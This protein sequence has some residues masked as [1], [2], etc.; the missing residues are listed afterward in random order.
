MTCF[1]PE[2]KD[3]SH[4]ELPSLFSVAAMLE[5]MDLRCFP[6]ISSPPCNSLEDLNINCEKLRARLRSC[7]ASDF[8]L[9]TPPL[10]VA[11]AMVLLRAVSRAG[12]AVPAALGN[13][14]SAVP[15][16]PVSLIQVW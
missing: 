14:C 16:L 13:R 1:E 7:S 5:L 15:K 6:R 11:T 10:R 12:R 8:F 3:V 4:V 9:R 2:K